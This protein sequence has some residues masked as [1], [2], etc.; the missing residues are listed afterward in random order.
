MRGM[1]QWGNGGGDGSWVMYY[2][3]GCMENAPPR[4]P[5][6]YAPELPLEKACL[7]MV[8]PQFED[9]YEGTMQPKRDKGR[10]RGRG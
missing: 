6:G 4:P 5:S 8:W 1:G 3:C 2:L 10:D 9:A 7:F